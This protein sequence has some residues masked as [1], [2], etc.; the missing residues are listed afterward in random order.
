MARIGTF[1]KCGSSSIVMV[2]LVPR[3]LLPVH[4]WLGMKRLWPLLPRNGHRADAVRKAHQPHLGT[5][6][7]VCAGRVLQSVNK[8]PISARMAGSLLAS[9]AQSRF[10]A[11]SSSGPCPVA[12]LLILMVRLLPYAPPFLS[13]LCF[14]CLPVFSLGCFSFLLT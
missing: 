14:F 10:A 9:R 5:L 8:D 1:H 6:A 4:R 12:Q 7:L 13:P 3:V 2:E 11:V